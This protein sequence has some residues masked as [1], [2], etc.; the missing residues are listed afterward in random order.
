MAHKKRANCAYFVGLVHG[1]GK[2]DSSEIKCIYEDIT[3]E[4]LDSLEFKNLPLLSDHPGALLSNAKAADYPDL[5][6]GR[7]I[8]AITGKDGSKYVHGYID[9]STEK[10][11]E[12][13][14]DL[15][16]GK[17][18]LSLGNSIKYKIGPDG[19]KIPTGYKNDHVALVV[20]PGRPGCGILLAGHPREY[21]DVYSDI[22]QN[23][24]KNVSDEAHSTPPNGVSPVSSNSRSR[25]PKNMDQDA[26]MSSGQSSERPQS[27]STPT[28]Q[29]QREGGGGGDPNRKRKF[30][31]VSEDER[32]HLF[33][34]LSESHKQLEAERDEALKRAEKVK[35]YE[36][37]LAKY[38]EREEKENSARA[39][40]A[41]AR[42]EKNSKIVESTIKSFLASANEDPE[43]PYHGVNPDEAVQRLRDSFYPKSNCKEA[44]EQAET[45]MNNFEIMNCA[46]IHH[47][48]AL[49]AQDGNPAPMKRQQ[50]FAPTVPSYPSSSSGSSSSGTTLF[51]SDNREIYVPPLRPAS[52]FSTGPGFSTLQPKR[53]EL[54]FDAD[55]K[56]ALRP[57][58]YRSK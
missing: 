16:N 12:S 2:K 20:E 43:H 44:I 36:E 54:G 35:E 52:T 1:P 33:L 27:H 45:N 9:A 18:R 23:S 22:Y 14:R 32:E 13:I 19:R 49:Q 25:S 37:A 51:T 34:Q 15:R 7:I 57:R 17:F 31:E 55:L 29:S 4:S 8:G 39:A 38:K 30:S 53:E 46:S 50:R 58:A 41:K 5:E 48:R 28:H 47:R 42:A 3:Q 21:L 6:R 10:G 24:G 40:A 11:R 56:P 26:Q